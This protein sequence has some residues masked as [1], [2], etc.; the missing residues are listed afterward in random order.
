MWYYVHQIA[1]RFHHGIDGLVS[2]RSFVDDISVLTALDAGCRLGVVV[3]GE[4]ALASAPDMA[5]PAPWL[6]LMKLSGFR[7]CRV[8]KGYEI[9]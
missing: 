2:H 4:A 8:G 7:F 1:L 9:G 6:Q 5:R 3:Q